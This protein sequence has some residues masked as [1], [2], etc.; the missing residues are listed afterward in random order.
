MEELMRENNDLKEKMK[1]VCMN[2]ESIIVFYFNYA[3]MT[4]AGREK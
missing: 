4:L 1:K 3:F 2:Y